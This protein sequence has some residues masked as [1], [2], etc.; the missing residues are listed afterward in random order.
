[1][2]TDS[3]ELDT[4]GQ[5]TDSVGARAVGDG[6]TLDAQ[7]EE[8]DV[9]D[10]DL[11]VFDVVLQADAA[12]GQRVEERAEDHVDI[13]CAIERRAL[14]TGAVL[15]HPG[16]FFVPADR[17][18]TLTG[19]Q[20]G[21]HGQPAGDAG[22]VGDQ[23]VRRAECR[24]LTAG[25]TD[26]PAGSLDAISVQL[27]TNRLHTRSVVGLPGQYRGPGRVTGRLD[28]HP[29]TVMDERARSTAGSGYCFD[30]GPFRDFDR[31]RRSRCKAFHNGSSVRST[32]RTE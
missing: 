16:A 29:T 24:V 27:H 1:M 15:D 7:V 10:R 5:H 26:D 21:P 23:V 18:L 4:G 25:S 2:S 12:D 32:P 11:G 31:P 6:R 9:D 30:Q 3:V 13:E 14:V 22:L 19:G 28:A 20:G 8:I 17:H